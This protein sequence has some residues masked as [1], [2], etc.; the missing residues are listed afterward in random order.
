MPQAILKSDGERIVLWYDLY[1][2][3]ASKEVAS[4][5]TNQARTIFETTSNVAPES[6]GCSAPS[7]FGRPSTLERLSP[8][9]QK[10]KSETSQEDVKS[11]VRTTEMAIASLIPG[12]VEQRGSDLGVSH[13]M[14]EME[15]SNCTQRVISRKVLFIAGLS[16]RGRTEF[17]QHVVEHM[18]S[19]KDN[20]GQFL[21]TVCTFDNRGIGA[22]TIPTKKRKYSTHVMAQ[23]TLALLD[24]LG[25]SRTHIIGLSLGGMIA[26]KLAAMQPERVA[27]LTPIATTSCGWHMLA[28]IST[29]PLLATLAGVG[30]MKTRI[31][32]NLRYNFSE[33]YLK[34]R[35]EDCKTRLQVL[36]ENTYKA[37]Q[38]HD[39]GKF[40]AEG[41]PAAGR[42]GQLA[43]VFTHRLHEQEFRTISNASFPCQL[44]VGRHD[45]L[46]RPHFVNKMAQKLRCALVVV[47]AAHA[48]IMIEALQTL[49][50]LLESVVLGTAQS[51]A[52]RIN[53]LASDIEE[54]LLKKAE[55]A[56]EF[57]TSF[58][59]GHVSLSLVNPGDRKLADH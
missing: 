25:W 12:Q 50:Q 37:I 28:G 27:S 11:V 32:A 47:E 49:V 33:A 1:G 46:A 34:E 48:G 29:Q 53:Q 13:S 52:L 44:V 14:P 6:S 3:G 17:L 18:A 42:Q 19:L 4:G 20:N 7:I 26:T 43:A 36:V 16:A 51:S 57:A 24:H 39:T 23:D 2:A 54:Q 40:L 30:P 41:Q 35:V 58:A 31:P 45:R 15:A 22:S 9:I 55:Y 38:E 10:A 21:L 56:K 8:A 59:P 5:S